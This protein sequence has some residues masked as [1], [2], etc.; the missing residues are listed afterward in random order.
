MPGWKRS[1]IPAFV[2]IL[3]AASFSA[4]PGPSQP[5]AVRYTEGVTHGFLVLRNL[6][7]KV[8]AQGDVVQTV[9]PGDTVESRMIFRFQD[10][11]EFDE[12]V[13]Y[14]QHGSF[15]MHHYRVVQR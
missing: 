15:R 4:G 9:Q 6:E 11:S 2:L 12:R 14:T 3:S 7:N 10:G 8:I 1:A 13:R 5:I